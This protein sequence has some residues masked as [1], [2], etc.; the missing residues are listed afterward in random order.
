MLQSYNHMEKDRRP[1]ILMGSPYGLEDMSKHPE[2]VNNV[3]Q[4]TA[5]ELQLKGFEPVFFGPSVGDDDMDNIVQ[6]KNRL[7][8]AVGIPRWIA[9]LIQ[10]HYRYSLPFN[11]NEATLLMLAKQPDIVFMEEPLQGFFGHS[12]MSGMPSYENGKS[13]PLT[14]G[15]FHMHTEQQMALQLYF[16]I[17]NSLRRPSLNKHKIPNGKFTPGVLNT[18]IKRLD[19]RVAV[20]EITAEDWRR[21]YPERYDVIYNGIDTEVFNPNG[22]KIT[23][24]LKDGKQ[25]IFF[26]GRHDRR[27]GIKY[28]IEAY[29]RLRPGYPNT[30]LIIAGDGIERDNLIRMVRERNIPDVEFPGILSDKELVMAYRTA[31]VFSSLATGKEALGL[32]NLEAMACGVIPVSTDID[33]YREVLADAPLS[34]MVKPGNST[35]AANK[36]SEALNLSEEK[37]IRKGR[38]NALYVKK[39]FGLPV[40]IQK[41]ALLIENL[42]SKHDVIDWS[43]VEQRYA[44]ELI[45]IASAGDIFVAGKNKS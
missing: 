43:K 11:K 45:T 2:G 40:V 41:L 24:W 18:V 10:T 26:A 12:V 3:A 17:V 7:G 25:I 38:E 5:K 19:S 14:I 9:T 21:F 34:F 13:I 29:S 33:G 31:S 4:R 44:K 22:P 8:K 28:L 42:L 6:P 36:L 35:D 1:R 37:R 20:S 32:T 23:R 39:K 27:K 15:R 16:K 30:K